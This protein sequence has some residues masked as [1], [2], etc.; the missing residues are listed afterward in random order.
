MSFKNCLQW[1]VMVV[2]TDLSLA[3]SLPQRRGTMD[4]LYI[5]VEYST[6][7][8]K[9]RKEERARYGVSF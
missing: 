8:N 1:L 9:M 5:A 4:S 3:E 7:I 2:Y 6:I